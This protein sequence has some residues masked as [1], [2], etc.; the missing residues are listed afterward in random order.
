VIPWTRNTHNTQ[1]RL[2]EHIHVRYF[3]CQAGY[4]V[5]SEPYEAIQ[6]L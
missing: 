3:V 6:L 4:E 2:T 1:Y 5:G